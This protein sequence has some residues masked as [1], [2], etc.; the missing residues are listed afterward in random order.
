MHGF[1]RKEVP[2]A[3]KLT[4]LLIV[5]VLQRCASEEHPLSQLD[6]RKGLERDYDVKISRNTMSSYIGELQAHFPD[7]LRAQVRERMNCR[8]GSPQVISTNLYWMHEFSESEV[9]LIGDGVMAA[10]LPQAQKRELLEKVTGLNPHAG[11]GVLKHIVSADRK[12]EHTTVSQLLYNIKTLDQAISHKKRIQFYW[13]EYVAK[14]GK[15]VLE[16]TEDCAKVDPRQIVASDG[17]YYLLATYPGAPDKIYH[18]RIDVLLDVE[19][20]DEHVAKSTTHQDL[21]D[22]RQKHLM[23]FGGKSTATIR[24]R[25]EAPARLRVFDAFG[26]H[27]RV[28]GSTD[29]FI[30]FE[31]KA[32]LDAVRY[33]IKQNSEAVEAIAPKELRGSL[34]KDAR[35]MLAQYETS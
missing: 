23:M 24:V 29:G 5:E 20:L 22:Y 9:R 3:S 33:W 6:I 4:S 34:A 16:R 7:S 12:K 8:D 35:A 31:V 27:A 18:F 32:N 26:V 11:V 13:G 10:P 19:E 21:T 14:H 17:H 30:D 28:V 15:L 25:D 2:M 1:F